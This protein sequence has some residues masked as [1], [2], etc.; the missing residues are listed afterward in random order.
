MNVIKYKH[1]FATIENEEDLVSYIQKYIYFQ[2]FKKIAAHLRSDVL[3]LIKSD[4]CLKSK[5]DASIKKIISENGKII[6]NRSVEFWLNRGYDMNDAKLVI[7]K[8]Q[9]N[10]SPRCIDYWTSR[11]ETLDVSAIKISELQKSYGDNNKRKS[12][13]QLRKLSTRCWEYWVEKGL[14]EEDAKKHVQHRHFLFAREYHDTATPKQLNRH[15]HF[16]EKNGQYGKPAPLGSGNGWSGWYK[17]K[18]F[19]SL[20]ELSYIVNVLDRFSINY[21]LAESTR[22]KIPYTKSDGS[23]GT[24]FPDFIVNDK[25]LIEI[26]P[27]G[28]WSTKSVQLKANAA[29][30][31]CFEHGLKYKLTDPGY[32]TIN[33]LR[34]LYETGEVTFIPRVEK[35][36]RKYIYKHNEVEIP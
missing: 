15:R 10:C 17:G 32:L 11:G 6:S 3:D 28:L 12:K 9:R 21:E 5:F 2:H 24:Y 30:E 31:F 7:S 1:V 19:R 26:K 8:I 18:H 27:K 35:K 13:Q 36:V 14:S 20:Y 23:R 22:Y 33:K 34:Q 29:I 16:G 4:T 25:Y